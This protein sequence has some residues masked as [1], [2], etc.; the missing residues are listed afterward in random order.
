MFYNSN[1][2]HLGTYSAKAQR[3]TLHATMGDARGGSI[4]ARNILQHGLEWMKEDRFRETLTDKGKTM[5][6]RLV[7]LQETVG[8]VDYSLDG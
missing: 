8:Q 3:A 1:I 4:R 7:M 6:D 2:L 5:L